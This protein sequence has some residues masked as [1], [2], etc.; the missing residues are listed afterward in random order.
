MTEL[1]L[2]KVVRSLLIEE[3]LAAF[4]LDVVS[5][6]GLLVRWSNHHHPLVVTFYASVYV[7]MYV[8]MSVFTSLLMTLFMNE[9]MC[10]LVLCVAVQTRG[11]PVGVVNVQQFLRFLVDLFRRTSPDLLQRLRSGDDGKGAEKM[12]QLQVLAFCNSRPDSGMYCMDTFA[13]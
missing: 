1:V 10:L 4:V 13:G 7:C 12:A 8:I 9:L 11:T 6:T 5:D 2:G 3:T